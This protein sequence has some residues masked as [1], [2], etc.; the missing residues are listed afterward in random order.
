MDFIL[1]RFI[2]QAQPLDI[3]GFVI[4]SYI[5]GKEGL[6]HA[7]EILYLYTFGA[8]LLIMFTLG[9]ACDLWVFSHIVFTR[10]FLTGF[11]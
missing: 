4:L 2:L 11:N 7:V 8:L 9:S 6:T 1:I 5:L 3:M 10:P